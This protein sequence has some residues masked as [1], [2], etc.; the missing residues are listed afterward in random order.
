MPTL[1]SFRSA[2][3][4]GCNRGGG[5]RAGRMLPGATE[6]MRT[7]LPSSL[8]LLAGTVMLLAA[9]GCFDS[10]SDSKTPVGPRIGGKD[11]T[12]VYYIE[13]E[14]Y[15]EEITAR[16]GQDGDRVT[17]VTSRQSAPGRRFTGTV[18]EEGDL[19]LTDSDDGELWTNLDRTSEAHIRIGD[20][21]RQPTAIDRIEGNDVALKIVVLER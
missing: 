4:G 16:V 19:E 5:R 7:S 2:A 13:G 11:W 9:S 18:N 12:G 14:R 20:Y 10:G 21:V 3:A 6:A 1:R 15:P 8:R 17:I